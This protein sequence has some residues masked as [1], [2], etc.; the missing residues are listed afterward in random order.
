MLKEFL[1]SWRYS[2]AYRKKQFFTILIFFALTSIATV[3]PFTTREIISD[4][5]ENSVSRNTVIYFFIIFFILIF[6]K[7]LS[8]IVEYMFKNISSIVSSDKRY[9]VLD[10]I[11]TA[12]ISRKKK[13]DDSIIISRLLNEICCYGH[14]IG[15]FPVSVITNT[16]RVIFAIIV[17]TKINIYLFFISFLIIPFIIILV[18][19]VKKK[20]ED[21]SFKQIRQYEMVQKLL[22]EIFTAYTDIKQLKAE[23]QILKHFSKKNK[24]YLESENYFNKIMCLIQESSGILFSTLPLFCLFGG[25][26]LTAINK[27]DIG[28]AIAFYMYANFFVVPIVNFTDMKMNNIQSKKKEEMI[29]EIISSFK[30][31]SNYK[32]NNFNCDSISVNKILFTYDNG[33]TIKLLK[34]LLF[35]NPGLY[36]MTANSGF[37]K[38]TILKL[39]AKIFSSNDS[40]IIFDNNIKIKDISENTFF[41]KVT[42]MNGDPL[43]IEGTIEDNITYFGKYNLDEKYMDIL[44]GIDECIYRKR[45]LNIGEGNSLSTGQLQ[46]INILRLFAKGGDQKLIILDEAFSGIEEEKEKEI[47]QLLKMTFPQAVIILVTHRKSNKFLCDYIIDFDAEHVIRKN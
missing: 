36:Y 20:C 47:I 46:R 8:F 42:Y 17:L 19:I 10:T 6:N 40:E 22:K 26:A 16:I 25:I 43:F 12:S 32:N 29:N 31:E 35:N 39:M 14:L 37:G 27:C 33:K 30:S 44:F 13:F 38:T 18:N 3:I 9:E 5:Q 21:A 2:K 1:D 45:E 28:S 24:T 23:D 41:D 34:A 15:V 11:F 7:I 4:I